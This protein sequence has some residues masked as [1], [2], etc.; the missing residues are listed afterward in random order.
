MFFVTL[1]KFRLGWSG[2]EFMERTRELLRTAEK[3]PGV[4]VISMYWTLGRYDAV[5]ISECPD[6]KTYLKIAIRL[7]DLA[8]TETMVSIPGEEAQK[9]IE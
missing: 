8:S 1:I 2:E 7:S 4:K 3:I 6:E 9:L 5:L